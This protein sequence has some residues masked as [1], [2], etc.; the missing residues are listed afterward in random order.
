MAKRIFEVCVG[1]YEDVIEAIENGADRIELNCALPLGGLTPS[2]SLLKMV[3]KITEIPVVVMI[4]NRPGGFI[5]N[6]IEFEQMLREAIDLLEAGADGLVFG[7]LTNNLEINSY[8]T[9]VMKCISHS[10]G[11]EFVFHGALGRVKDYEG[12]VKKLVGLGVDRILTSGGFADVTAGLDGLRKIQSLYGEK[13]EILAGCG[14]TET[15]VED[16]LKAGILQIHG[17]CKSYRCDLSESNSSFPYVNGQRVK[18]IA[19]IVHNF[20]TQ[21]SN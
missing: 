20:K 5:Y 14:V 7:S 12:S 11:K 3:K 16:L 9:S 15:N 17:T 6:Q 1:S 10:Y 18:T 8:Q 4:R 13:I 19:N 2:V 21:T